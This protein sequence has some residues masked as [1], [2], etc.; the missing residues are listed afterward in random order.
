VHGLTIIE[1]DGRLPADAEMDEIWA[2]A[3][4]ALNAQLAN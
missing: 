3:L 1:L 4:R 2:Y